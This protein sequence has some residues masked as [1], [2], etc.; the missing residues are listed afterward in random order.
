MK[1]EIYYD[2]NHK[3]HGYNPYFAT[4][5]ENKPVG[6]LDHRRIISHTRQAGLCPIHSTIGRQLELLNK[7]WY[8]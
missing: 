1:G 3:E 7:I 6:D 8:R 4:D 2:N 5:V